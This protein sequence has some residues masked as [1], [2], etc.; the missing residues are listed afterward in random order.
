MNR[1]KFYIPSGTTVCADA[2]AQHDIVATHLGVVLKTLIGVEGKTVREGVFHPQHVNAHHSTL[3]NWMNNWFKG[4]ASKYLYR[5]VGWR[6]AL[7]TCDFTLQRLIEK[8]AGVGCINYKA[9]QSLTQNRQPPA[10]WELSTGLSI[11]RNHVNN[12]R[13]SKQKTQSCFYWLDG[14]RRLVFI[15]LR[16]EAPYVL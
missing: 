9:E 4:V 16:P 8:L 10:R 15:T 7:S 6:R 3:K 5:Y 11:T 13:S 1:G 14:P 2:L 12:A